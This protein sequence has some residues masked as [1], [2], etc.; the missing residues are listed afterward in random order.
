MHTFSSCEMPTG[1]NV[2]TFTAVPLDFQEGVPLIILWNPN[3]LLL[4]LP[5]PMSWEHPEPTMDNI[6]I[7]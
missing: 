6:D 7:H 1:A 3:L 2:P 4:F 5:S